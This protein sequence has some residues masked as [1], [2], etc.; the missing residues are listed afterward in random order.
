MQIIMMLIYVD[1]ST[2]KKYGTTSLTRIDIVVI[3]FNALYVL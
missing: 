1:K 2:V 3:C